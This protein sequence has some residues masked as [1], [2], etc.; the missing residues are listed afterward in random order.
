MK[1][2]FKALQAEGAYTKIVFDDADAALFVEK[3]RQFMLALGYHP[4]TVKDFLG[5]EE[6]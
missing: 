1:I 3:C 5:P 2:I 4:L 6:E